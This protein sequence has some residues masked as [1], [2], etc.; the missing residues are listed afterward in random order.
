MEVLVG[1]ITVL[2]MLYEIGVI[3]EVRVMR[4]EY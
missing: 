3:L 4:G 2:F 1:V